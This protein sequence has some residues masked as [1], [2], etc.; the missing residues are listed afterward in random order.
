MP[1]TLDEFIRAR[2]YAFHLTARANE[3]RIRRTRTLCPASD[4]LIA[5]G[6][7]ELISVRRREIIVLPV[8]GE[9]IHVRDQAP[10]HEGNIGFEGGWTM[11]DLIRELN[12]RVFFWPGSRDRAI[13][14]AHRHFARYQEESP[15]VL[16]VSMRSLLDVNPGQLPAFCKFNSGS[17]R[18]SSGRKSPRGPQTFTACSDAPFAR[19][20]VVEVTFARAI[21]LPNNAEFA[22]SYDGP[23]RNFF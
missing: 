14:Y 5:A 12:E 22:N 3:A 7:P 16:R 13:S 18:C 19:G 1:F 11:A 20:H 15:L 2:P 21:T 8:N 17:P 4:I 23:W 10:L 9:L 6:Q